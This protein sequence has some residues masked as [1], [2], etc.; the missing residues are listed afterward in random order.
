ML[1]LTPNCRK[2]PQIDNPRPKVRSLPEPPRKKIV[3]PYFV[4]K[5]Y[6]R[7]SD[8]VLPQLMVFNEDPQ[9]DKIEWDL[10]SGFLF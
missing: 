3:S 2:N 1:D 4:M 5:R 8:S 9:C 10:S 7:S 6:N